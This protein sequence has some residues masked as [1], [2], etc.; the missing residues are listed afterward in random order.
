MMEALKKVPAELASRVTTEYLADLILR[1]GATMLGDELAGDGLTEPERELLAAQVEDLQT[2]REQDE[3]LFKLKLQEA[4]G[5]LG[6]SRYFDPQQ[7]GLQAQTAAK[8]AGAQQMRE[9]ERDAALRPGRGGM[10][11]E[12]RRRAGLDVTARAQTAYA[13]GAESGQRQKLATYQ[14]GLAAL[15]TSGPTA[16]LQYSKNLMDMFGVANQRRQD[17]RDSVGEWFGGLTG[18]RTAASIG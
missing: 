15:P 14:A 8:V 6:E 18:S 17:A 12:D 4:I 9:A 10:S 7:F 11:A 2:L 16:G 13:Q 3:E 1:G 5:L